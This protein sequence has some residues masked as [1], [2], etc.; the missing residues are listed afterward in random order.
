MRIDDFA[1][2]CNANLRSM[3]RRPTTSRPA[4]TGNV[5]GNML[6]SVNA[7]IRD[8]AARLRAARKAKQ[9]AMK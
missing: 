4:V 9:A 3:G 5:L 1:S 8:I 7:G 2:H 6:R